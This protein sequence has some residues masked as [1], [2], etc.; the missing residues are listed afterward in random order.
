MQGQ[1]RPPKQKSAKK[2][3]KEQVDAQSSNKAELNQKLNK[4]Q[5]H[6]LDIQD[7]KTRKR[8]RKNARMR[9]KAQKGRSIPFYKRW[10]HRDKFKS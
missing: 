7:K 1:K 5:T 2:Q 6:H 4:A 9:K 10:F 8:M 3:A